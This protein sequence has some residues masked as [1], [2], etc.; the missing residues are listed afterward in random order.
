M[1][2]TLLGILITLHY[3]FFDKFAGDKRSSLFRP[4]PVK[5]R[6]KKFYTVD[7]RSQF[8]LIRKQLFNDDFE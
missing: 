1:R 8:L 7:T 2:S 6:R 5:E 4:S 3:D